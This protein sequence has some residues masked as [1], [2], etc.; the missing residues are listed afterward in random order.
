[1][2]EDNFRETMLLTMSD[3]IA[4]ATPKAKIWVRASRYAAEK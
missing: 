2:R 1:M 3:A 4:M